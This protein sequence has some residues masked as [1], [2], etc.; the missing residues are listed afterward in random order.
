V[1]RPNDCW[2]PGLIVDRLRAG[3]VV[4]EN[5]AQRL[6]LAGY[7]LDP[8]IEAF[9]IGAESAGIDTLGPLIASA[10]LSADPGPLR[11]RLRR[12]ATGT[13]L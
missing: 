12:L 13:L 1:T 6:M 10:A 5:W 3:A 2:T 8:E 11:D 9:V 4:P 7:Q